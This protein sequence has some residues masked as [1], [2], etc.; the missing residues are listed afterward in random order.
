MD[1][2]E[3]Q[4]FNV[5]IATAA[6][7]VARKPKFH[8]YVEREDIVSHL[9]EWTLKHSK[10]ERS[11]LSRY[12]DKYDAD[13]FDK[14][15]SFVLYD[16]ANIYA[17]KEKA[18]ALGYSAADEFF[19]TKPALE[20][21]LSAMFDRDAWM[22]PPTEHG[23]E[24]SGKALNEGNNWLATLSDVSQAYGRLDDKDRQVLV[25]AFRDD[26]PR[27]KLAEMWQLSR[28]GVDHR[29]EASVKRLWSHLGGPK[30]LAPEEREHGTGTIGNRRSISN[31]HARALTEG[32]YDAG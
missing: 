3:V 23:T 20:D 13:E 22:N 29:I 14:I 32:Q 21:L 19:F 24:K 11:K 15:V 2:N 27:T 17:R 16:E 1:D 7:S 9:W 6:Y 26:V 10:D 31:A 18:Q 4:A 28:K 12:R 5:L 30:W 8:G 25:L